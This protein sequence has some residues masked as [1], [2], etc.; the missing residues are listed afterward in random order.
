VIRKEATMEL[1]DDQIIE[2]ALE[3][4]L[5]D[6]YDEF[7]NKSGYQET[8]WKLR[9]FLKIISAL[10]PETEPNP[11]DLKDAERFRWAVE[12]GRLSS[13]KT[14]SFVRD[15]IDFA[16]EWDHKAKTNP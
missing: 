15:K 9:M 2:A 4:D 16:M 5:W 13:N 8:M 6:I 7:Q 3:V 14:L 11:E 1:T 10:D 12:N